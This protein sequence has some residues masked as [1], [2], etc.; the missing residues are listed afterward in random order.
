MAKRKDFEHHADKAF[1]AKLA[2]E[3]QVLKAALKAYDGVEKP[4]TRAERQAAGEAKRRIAA[5]LGI[6]ARTVQRRLKEGR[7][8]SGRMSLGKDTRRKI[9]DDLRKRPEVRRAALPPRKT[10]QR[11]RKGV[12]VGLHGKIGTDSPKRRGSNYRSRQI[13]FKGEHI[14]LTPEQVEDLKEL[15]ENGDIDALHE[16]MQAAIGESYGRQEGGIPD[17]EFA[18]DEVYELMFMEAEADTESEGEDSEDW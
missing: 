5:E 7:E 4:R 13:G 16:A 14:Q 1:G 18:K 8:R 3:Y 9:M 2:T 10:Q 17:F 6:S 11:Q 12:Q 15:W